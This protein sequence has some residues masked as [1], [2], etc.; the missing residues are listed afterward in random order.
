MMASSLLLI[1]LLGL[2]LVV[3]EAGL[4]GVRRGAATP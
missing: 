3:L 4:I 2:L 1:T